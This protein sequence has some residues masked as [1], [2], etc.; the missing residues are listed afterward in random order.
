[1]S[2]DVPQQKSVA[3]GSAVTLQ[4]S[5]TGDLDSLHW[6]EAPQPE[7]AG[8]AVAVCIILIRVNGQGNHY[9]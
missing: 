4:C 1:M 2:N 5:R 8:V 9:F 6:V 7:Q 3:I